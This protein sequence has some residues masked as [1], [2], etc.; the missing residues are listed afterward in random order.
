MYAPGP[1]MFFL[2]TNAFELLLKVLQRLLSWFDVAYFPLAF[3]LSPIKLYCPGP[4]V[5]CRGF[6]CF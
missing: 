1:G 5:N 3:R 4:G 6:F 2:V